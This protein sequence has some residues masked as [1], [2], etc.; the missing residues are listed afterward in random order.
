VLG[1]QYDGAIETELVAPDPDVD[2]AL[3]LV[4]AG[5]GWGERRRLRRLPERELEELLRLSDLS[6]KARFIQLSRQ[7]SKRLASIVLSK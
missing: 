4:P 7:F 5:A 3:G 1:S 6:A 2:S